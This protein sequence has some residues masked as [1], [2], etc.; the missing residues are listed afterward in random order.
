MVVEKIMCTYVLSKAMKWDSRLTF[1]HLN[2][3]TSMSILSVSLL[4]MAKWFHIRGGDCL[5]NFQIERKE[6]LSNFLLFCQSQDSKLKKP[7]LGRFPDA[8]LV[9]FVNAVNAR[10]SYFITVFNKFVYSDVH[11]LNFR[12]TLLTLQVRT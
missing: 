3:Q 2:L 8:L 11:F 6:E 12:A 9:A 10:T 5:E 1:W 7:K 4:C